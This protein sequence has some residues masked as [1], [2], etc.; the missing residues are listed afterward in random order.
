MV[1]HGEQALLSALL[2][3]E[4][5]AFYLDEFEGAEE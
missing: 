1:L 5:A 3:D 2:G 4:Q